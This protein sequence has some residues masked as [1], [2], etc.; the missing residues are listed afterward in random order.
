MTALVETTQDWDQF[1]KKP[2]VIRAK[3]VKEE[4]IIHTLEGEML[5]RVGDWLIE[6]IEGELYPCKPDIFELT[7]EP[8]N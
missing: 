6:G 3:K 2:I 8:V 4:M 1:R 7:Y 5:A